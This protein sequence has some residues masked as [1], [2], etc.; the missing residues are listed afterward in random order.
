M[1]KSAR[2]QRVLG[3]YC[4]SILPR[5]G[6][7]GSEIGRGRERSETICPRNPLRE[8]KERASNAV[9]QVGDETLLTPL[10]LHGHSLTLSP[11]TATD[12]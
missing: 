4:P 7:G 12:E 1:V 9:Q 3:M 6:G 10:D 5:I 11:S 2:T 8:G